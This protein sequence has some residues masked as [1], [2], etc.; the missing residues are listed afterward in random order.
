MLGGYTIVATLWLLS[1]GIARDGLSR[2]VLVLA[3]TAGPALFGV[4]GGVPL[5]VGFV[6][7][8]KTLGWLRTRLGR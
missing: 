1:D 4:L 2:D 5:L 7:S 6:V 3:F 8:A